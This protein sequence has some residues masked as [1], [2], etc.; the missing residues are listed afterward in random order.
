MPVNTPGPAPN[1]VRAAREAS[2]LTQAQAAEL[3]HVST[4]TWAQ[5]E[6]IKP[7]SPRARRMPWG[8]FELF[9]IKNMKMDGGVKC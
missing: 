5:W 6:V 2:G 1:V 7:G 9:C 4:Q 3:V 8:L